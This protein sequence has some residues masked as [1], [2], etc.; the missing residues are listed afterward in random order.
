[1]VGNFRVC[2]A[3]S[4]RGQA[5]TAPPV[6]QRNSRRLINTPEVRVGRL[7]DVRPIA[8]PKKIYR[9]TQTFFRIVSA[10]TPLETRPP[11]CR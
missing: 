8:H 9:P 2:C 3:R 5:A 1:M 7:Y 11:P 6:R 10:S 4:K